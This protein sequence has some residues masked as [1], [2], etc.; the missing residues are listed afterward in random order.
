MTTYL[1][2]RHGQRWALVPVEMKKTQ[3]RAGQAI[4]LGS[5]DWAASTQAAP[6]QRGGTGWGLPAGSEQRAP[7]NQPLGTQQMQIIPIDK[8][9]AALER[10]RVLGTV[11][12]ANEHAAVAQAMGISEELVREADEC[13]ECD[14]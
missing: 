10:V 7:P 9:K 14:A 6:D 1:T 12:R 8:I 2:D 3:V 13:Q 11:S 4:E 5:K